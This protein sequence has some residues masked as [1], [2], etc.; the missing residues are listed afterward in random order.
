[1]PDS[2][3]KLG[4]GASLGWSPAMQTPVKMPRGM[5]SLYVILTSAYLFQFFVPISAYKPVE[6]IALNCSSFGNSTA[7]PYRL[8]IG[9]HNN[10]KH[11]PIEQQPGSSV[12][13][14]VTT[15]NETFPIP[16]STARLSQSEFT[17]SLSI[18]RGPKLIRLQFHVSDDYLN[19]SRADALFSVRCNYYTLLRNVSASLMAIGSPIFSKEFCVYVQDDSLLLNI[20]LTP[21]TEYNPNAYALI[22]GIQIVSMPLDLYYST[23][24]RREVKFLGNHNGNPY[25]LTSMD[26]MEAMHRVNIGGAIISPDSVTDLYRSWSTDDYYLTEDLSSVLPVN[27]SIPLVFNQIPDYA[28]PADLYRTA[29]SMGTNRSIT[30]SYKLTWSFLVDSNFLYLV[31]LHFCEFQRE[32]SKIGDRTFEIYIASLV[33]ERAADVIEWTGGRGIP[34]YKDYAVDMHAP[35][36]KKINLTV[37]LHAGPEQYSVYAD[38]LLNGVEVFKISDYDRNLAGP[39]PAPIR[40]EDPLQPPQLP[41]SSESGGISKKA[42]AAI[43]GGSVAGALAFSLLCFLT[44]RRGSHSK[45]STYTDKTT[46]WQLLWHPTTKLTKTHDSSMPG[47]LCRRFSLAEIKAATNGFHEIFIVG[48][49]GFGNVYKGYMNGGSTPVAIKR[50]NPGSQQGAREFKTEIEMLTMVK[51]TFGYLDPEYFRFHRLTEKSDV[52]SF[53]VVLFE[54]EEI[55]LA[56]WAQSCYQNGSLDQ[57]IDHNLKAEITPEWLEKFAE[58]AM[59]CLRDEGMKRPSMNDIVRSLEL[60]LQLQEGGVQQETIALEPTSAMDGRLQ[61][62][63]DIESLPDMESDDEEPKRGR[64]KGDRTTGRGAALIS[65]TTIIVEVAR[66]EASNGKVK[67][68]LQKVEGVVK[69]DAEYV[70]DSVKELVKELMDGESEL[71]TK[72]SKDRKDASLSSSSDEEKE[73]APREDNTE[74]AGPA[75][76]VEE[77]VE[78]RLR[79]YDFACKKTEGRTKPTSFFVLGS[80]GC[81]TTTFLLGGEDDTTSFLFL[82][83]QEAKRHHF[84]FQVNIV[85]SQQNFDLYPYVTLSRSKNCWHC[86]KMRD[87]RDMT[88]YSP[89]RRT[90]ICYSSKVV[91][92]AVGRVPAEQEDDD[93]SKEEISLRCRS[94][95]EAEREGENQRII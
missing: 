29:R 26:A 32:I 71:A 17:Y 49:G 22:S 39:N 41:P 27:W 64:G 8:W 45:D 11:S 44:F 14:T 92:G 13:R 94:R 40:V 65:A 83:V 80:A 91:G 25:M 73:E 70:V 61:S 36:S 6:D 9:D 28:A 5:C 60:T 86:P 93:V 1:M 43:A 42:I 69:E 66:E 4:P 53:G 21:S 47:D 54:T 38:A 15:V 75:A 67:E 59:R 76:V 58:T 46:L 79:I 2:S 63:E 87:D 57:I 77:T 68:A 74:N 84:V 85:Y 37:S 81:Q 30:T 34:I 24:A 12:I 78:G 7:T 89:P 90:L 20:T 52:Y 95:P 82:G 31:R 51:G 19:F 33:A 35:T 88:F 18:T 50:L 16:Y 72:E 23:Y 55:G 62:G 3:E 48:A 56:G 10:M